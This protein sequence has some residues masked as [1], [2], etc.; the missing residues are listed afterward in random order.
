MHYYR[1]VLWAKTRQ[2]RYLYW[3]NQLNCSA[4][5]RATDGNLTIHVFC[6]FISVGYV[7]I[8]IFD[9]EKHIEQKRWIH[10]TCLTKI[11]Y[12]SHQYSM[13]RVLAVEWRHNVE[14]RCRLS[15]TRV[16]EFD[17]DMYVELLQEGMPS[18]R[19]SSVSDRSRRILRS[20]IQGVSI[21]CA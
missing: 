12:W 6:S 7:M 4:Y 3:W 13:F 21:S 8:L 2:W 10:V 18:L 1:F 15:D 9:I 11:L 19:K 17:V 5:L 20:N 14:C 16:R